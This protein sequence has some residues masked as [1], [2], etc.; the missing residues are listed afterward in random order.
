MLPAY[1]SESLQA[2]RYLVRAE[3]LAQR[4]GVKGFGWKVLSHQ[5]DDRPYLAKLLKQHGYRAIYLKRNSVRQVL[6]G[7]VA[8]QRGI[9]N[10]LEKIVDERR[11]YIKLDDFQRRVQWE[12]EC[13]KR[14]CAW[15]RAEG[16][17]F[18]EVSYEDFC[19]NREIFYGKIF[20]LLNMPLELPP[21]SNFV[22][23][24]K[25]PKMVIENYDEVA[26][27]AAALGEAL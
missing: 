16:F 1:Y 12:R 7:M 27:V 22:K 19:D 24:I 4:K 2:H 6:S 13:V 26:D 14:D 3:E 23:M 9:Y 10:S 20:S 18:V 5:L 11:Y 21:P 17:D 8:N 25:D 15:L